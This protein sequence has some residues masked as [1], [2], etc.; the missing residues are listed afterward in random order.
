MITGGG[1]RRPAPRHTARGANRMRQIGTLADGP[2][3]HRLADY[4]LTQGIETQLTPQDGHWE[5]WVRDEDRVARARDELVAF[6]ANPDEPRFRAAARR[7]ADLRRDEE[8]AD[9]LYRKRQVDFGARMRGSVRATRPVTAGLIVFCVFVYVLTGWGNGNSWLA[10]QLFI[11]PFHT[12]DGAAYFNG[13]DA[14]ARGQVWRLV[15]PIFLHFSP[16]HLIGNSFWLYYLGAQIEARRG[17]VRYLALVLV[18]AVLSNLAEYYLGGLRIGEG[19]VTLQFHPTF[20]GMSGVVFGLFGFVWMKMR[21]QPELGLAMS[22]DAIVFS[23]LWLVFCFS[24]MAG[25]VANAAHAGGLLIGIA[26]GAAPAILR[27]LWR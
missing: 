18:L 4:L 9:H 27:G 20:G 1:P 8:R 6:T 17:P 12:A 22:G 14:I 3:A 7:A 15:T 26:I 10:Q 13:L 11:T 16:W 24:G 25:P 21:F 19:R 5:V 2:S 23:L